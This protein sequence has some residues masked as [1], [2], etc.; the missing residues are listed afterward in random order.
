MVYTVSSRP[1]RDTW[2]TRAKGAER[3]G[4]WMGGGGLRSPVSM[5]G[6]EDTGTS[7]REAV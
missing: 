6:E 4:Q 1:A 3:T 5:C 2:F 7:C